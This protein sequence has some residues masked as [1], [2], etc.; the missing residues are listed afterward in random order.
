MLSY[1]KMPLSYNV[2]GS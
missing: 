1:Y 2:K